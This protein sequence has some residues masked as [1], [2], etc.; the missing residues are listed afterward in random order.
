MGIFEDVV[1]D[2]RESRG[3]SCLRCLLRC[4][5]CIISR[6]D[7]AHLLTAPRAPHIFVARSE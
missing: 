3:T 7:I 5:P 1:S 2:N 6:N 4:E